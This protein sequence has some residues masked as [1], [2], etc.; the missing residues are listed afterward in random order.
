MFHWRGLL[1]HRSILDWYVKN[2]VHVC[3]HA[4][5]CVYGVC[6]VVINRALVKEKRH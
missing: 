6:V 3:I 5:F 1:K 2:H 4:V